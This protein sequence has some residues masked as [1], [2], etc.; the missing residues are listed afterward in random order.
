MK[1]YS[2]SKL[3][4]FENCAFQYKL[5]YIDNIKVDK[6]T[7]E[8]FLGN[9]VHST[10]EYTYQNRENLLKKDKP[11]EAMTELF[12]YF[13][14]KDYKD[15]ITIVKRGKG[16]GD[17][18]SA[19][20]RCIERYF[21]KYYPF[22]QNKVLGME[23]RIQIKLD[24][25]GKYLLNGIIDRLDETPGGGLEI[26]DY[27]TGMNPPSQEKIEKERQ[28]ALYHIGVAEKYGGRKISLIWHYL[29][30]G[31]EFR[32]EKTE[33]QLQGVKE[34][35]MGVINEIE[36]TEEFKTHKGPLCNYCE[37]FGSYCR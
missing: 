17:Y 28:L 36:A 20:A 26:H 34:E 27:K 4:T 13:W 6:D 16:A 11:K 3:S 7:I 30:S 2:Y 25:E 14:R 5:R 21:D 24:A 31:I 1:I 37:Y 22:D 33:S 8:R 23:E 15:S 35:T 32:L 29:M 19:G 9:T 18:K 10:L 12:N